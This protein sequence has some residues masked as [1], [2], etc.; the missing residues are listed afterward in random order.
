MGGRIPIAFLEGQP[1]RPVEID[2]LDKGGMEAYYLS[3]EEGK[4][5]EDE[6][7][8][9]LSEQALEDLGIKKEVV[10]LVP[11]SFTLRGQEYSYDM[12]LSGW[13]TGNSKVDFLIVSEAFLEHNPEVTE[14]TYNDDKE[15]SGTYYASVCM[16]NTK[17]IEQNLKEYVKS[18][19]G[20]TE[21]SNGRE[22]IHIA[23]NYVL[24][25][26]EGNTGIGLSIFFFGALFILC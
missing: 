11:M 12:R 8:V 24:Y 5:P 15:V 26:E 20:Q 14:N 13:Y 6:K 23:V 2:Y 1:K 19:G 16:K 3:L 7:E 9:L 17:N 18:F 22:Y 25:S 21:D 4:M 10:S